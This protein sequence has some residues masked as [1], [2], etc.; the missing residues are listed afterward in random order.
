M[1]LTA[2]LLFSALVCA[3]FGVSVAQEPEKKAKE[4]ILDKD[5]K[6]PNNTFEY[7]ECISTDSLN[8]SPA[9]WCI[10]EGEEGC[11]EYACGQRKDCCCEGLC[12]TREKDLSKK[13]CIPVP[14]NDTSNKPSH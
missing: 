10:K 9:E 2:F 13:K 12:C 11:G 3:Y 8:T 4:P 5:I 14:G 1:K 7:G 6:D